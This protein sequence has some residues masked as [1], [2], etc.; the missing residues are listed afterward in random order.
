MSLISE[1]GIRIGGVHE[2]GEG[3]DKMSGSGSGS[4]SENEREDKSDRGQEKRTRDKDI[5]S[6]YYV[7]ITMWVMRYSDWRKGVQKGGFLY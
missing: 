5:K 7:R 3:A 2:G 6:N 1:V 4:E